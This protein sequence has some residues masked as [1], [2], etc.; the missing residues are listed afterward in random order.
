[1]CAQGSVLFCLYED[2]REKKW[3]VQAV[4][5]GPGS[6][7][8][9]RSLPAAWRGLRDAALST[10]SGIPGGVFVHAGGFIGGN[11]T[12]DGA[13]AMAAAALTLD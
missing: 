12:L 13:L 11:D 7:D 3:R 9:R 2:T 5:T 4:S 10:A 1:M 6:F 8:N